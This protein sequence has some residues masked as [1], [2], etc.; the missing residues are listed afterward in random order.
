MPYTVTHS[1]C[2]KLVEPSPWYW[3][4]TAG[5][6]WGHPVTDY[7]DS[8]SGLRTVMKTRQQPSPQEYMFILF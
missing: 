5:S 4:E 3:D 2:W 6:I 8:E 7:G 1:A